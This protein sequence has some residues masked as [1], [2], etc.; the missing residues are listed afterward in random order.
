MNKRTLVLGASTKPDR[1]SNRA[2]QLLRSF[3]HD[4]IAVGSDTGRV[5]D[6][7][8]QQ[9]FP[10]NEAINTLTLYI[11]PTIQKTYY[12]KILKLKPQRI[13][14]NPGTE[15]NELKQLAEQNGIETEE[16]CT[17]VLLNTGQY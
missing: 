16:A 15:N 10:M 2:I 12:D 9:T 13:I 7:E 14:F 8:I 6:V 3:H 1:Y 5:G 17:L 11:N 4:V